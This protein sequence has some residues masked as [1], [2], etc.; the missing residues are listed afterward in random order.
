MNDDSN[1]TIK[2]VFPEPR[3]KFWL[4][5]RKRPKS[6]A[7]SISSMDISIESDLGKQKKRRRITEVASSIF[8]S[9]TLGKQTNILHRSFTIQ[10]S[11]TDL[12][13]V[14]NESDSR[15]LTKK[16]KENI[17]NT[18]SLTLKSWVLDV[19][20]ISTKDRSNYT[21]SRTE[22]KRQE[23]IY[24]LYCGENVLINDLSVLKDFYY[25]PLIPTGIFNSEE[26]LT[27]FGGIAHLIEIHT[28][29]R[30]ELVQLRDQNGCTDIVGPT[31][32]NWTPTLTEPYL[33]RCRTQIWAKH[34]LDEKRL[35]NKRFQSFL[36]KRLESPHSI[37]LWTYIDV[38]RSRIVKYPLLVKEILRH[39]PVSHS[40]QSSLKEAYDMLSKLLNDIDGIMGAAECKLAQSKIHVKSE[41]DPCK[42]VES[43]TELITEGQLKDTRGIKFQCFLF[44]TGFVITRRTR[45]MSKKYNLSSPVISKEQ[46]CM[47]TEDK[48]LEI[49]E[50]K[51]GD[52]VFTT[53]DG[54]GK[55]HWID[56]LS[57]VCRFRI[58][59]VENEIDVNEKENKVLTPV[60]KNQS[61]RS[62][63]NKISENNFLTL[64]RS[65]L[66]Q[67]R[68]SIDCT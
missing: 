9:S 20:N 18:N 63:I 26:L 50:F 68:N 3:K 7:V 64:K 21:L 48:S 27:V 44:D 40:D 51:I 47:N 49:C 19:A 34:L 4:R 66:R 33:E 61:S 13:F 39:T 37:D 35:M 46:M 16:H 43:A 5:S 55:R 22:V 24:E 23:A 11:T 10:Q 58:D 14:D 31:I 59:S 8:S 57:K 62:T 42:C 28:R 30:D 36:K 12:S 32:L 17:E 65:F 6:D 25:E 60:K 41:Y 45:S 15:T 2:N 38:A 67:K 54:H 56:S 1:S 52:Y 29:L 53:E